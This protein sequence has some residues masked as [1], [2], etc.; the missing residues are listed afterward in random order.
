MSR[1]I[2]SNS[3]VLM[4]AEIFRKILRMVLVITAARILGREL[5]GGFSWAMGFTLL[6]W[7]LADMGIHQL[8]IREIARRPEDV[9]KYLSNALAIKLLLSAGRL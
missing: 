5:Y 3:M 6:F 2:L 7:I 1:R 9:K 8:I 4:G